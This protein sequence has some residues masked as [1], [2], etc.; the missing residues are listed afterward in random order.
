MLWPYGSR[1]RTCKPCS[2]IRIGR[3]FKTIFLVKSDSRFKR[4][5]PCPAIED[6]SYHVCKSSQ[7][8]VAVGRD[9]KDSA[10]CADYGGIGA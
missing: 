2:R 7:Y 3:L 9:V 5:V 4:S 1:G 10:N 8:P 6:G